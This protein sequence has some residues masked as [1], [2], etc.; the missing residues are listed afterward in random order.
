MVTG[1]AG[2]I[3]SHTVDR[4]LAEGHHVY[5]IDDLSTGSIDNLKGA[6]EHPNFELLVQDLVQPR[7]LE[8]FCKRYSPDA[9]I[10]LAALV[11]V[12]KAEEDPELN[13]RLNIQATHAVAE[14][15]RRSGV[16]RIVFAS[17][18]AVY[19]D[20][21]EPPIREISEPNPIG[22]Y[23]TAKL[24]GEFLL[25]QVT[26]S[27]G[28]TTVRNRYFN[29]FGP[30]QDPSSPYSGVISLFTDR[31]SRGEPVTI[32]GDGGQTRDFVSV[33]DVAAA[34]T[35]AATRDHVETGSYNICTG[36]SR[37]LLELVDILQE[38]YPGSPSPRFADDRPG[39]IR[40]SLGCPNLAKEGLGFAAGVSFRDGIAELTASL[41]SSPSEVS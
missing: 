12:V 40:D 23:G 13:F 9:I 29:V 11:S 19:G 35:I 3:G 41:E 34:N 28:I 32:F 36:Q 33:H 39:D 15:A 20:T 37:S 5:G 1:A 38:V 4:L 17:S 27:Y 6:M 18:A 31:F 21:P 24:I 22:N 2:F 30:R 14:A 10:H 8:Y 26:R 25:K 7:F 16:G